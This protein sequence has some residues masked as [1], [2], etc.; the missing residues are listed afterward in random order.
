M[1]TLGQDFNFRVIKNFLNKD[2]IMLLSN[3]CK[4]KHVHNQSSFCPVNNNYDTYYYGD[5][6]MES[7]V[8]LKQKIVEQE[9]NLK[10]LPSY[11]YWRF[12]TNNSELTKHKDRPTC[13]VSISMNIDNCGTSWPIFMDGTPIDLDKGDAVLYLGN[14][15]EHYRKPLEGDFSAQCFLHYV[16][17]NGKHVDAK[18]D[19]R[20][21]LGFPPIPPPDSD[22]T[23]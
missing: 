4:M 11:S 3:Y 18:Y 5:L 20:V 15:V 21:D 23:K 2:E 8:L 7:L 19:R 9:S 13:E 1:G 12:Y 14:L 16:N 22:F 6:I 10:L 17:A